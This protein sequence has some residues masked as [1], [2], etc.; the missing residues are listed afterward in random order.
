M[1][2]AKTCRAE[3]FDGQEIRRLVEGFAEE[4]SKHLHEEIGTLRGLVSYD[5]A[6]IRQA[7]QRFEKALMDTDNVCQPFL[8]LTRITKPSKFHPTDFFFVT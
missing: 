7:Y 4:L 6:R 3:D 5:S 2:Y 8:S 1:E